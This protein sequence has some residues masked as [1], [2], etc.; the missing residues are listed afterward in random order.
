MACWP[1]L[2]AELSGGLEALGGALEG[3]ERAA[4]AVSGGVDSAFLLH[5]ARE[6]LGAARVTGV[7][8]RSRLQ[9]AEEAE[10]AAAACRAEG[11]R[12]VVVDFEPLAV[13]GFAANPP[14]RCYLCK[15]ALFGALLERCAAE[16]LGTLA[17]GTNAD[18][19]GDYRPGL[20]ALRELGVRSPLL[21]AGLGK[22]AVRELSRAMGLVMWDKPS[23]ACL[24][25]RFPH[26][27]R[28]AAEGLARVEAAERLV[29]GTVAGVRQLRV[30]VH[31]NVARIETER[32]SAGAVLARA[33]DVAAGLR[34]LGYRYVALDLEGF[35]SGSLNPAAEEKGGGR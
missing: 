2:N 3:M 24:A 31:G 33:G 15:R 10:D 12:Q 1:R 8:A 7:T 32:E 16:G 21:E 30:R 5:V 25:T 34:G 13:E 17:E 14:E 22:A 11:V 27:D 20:R 28:I 6:V 18:D 29:R 23:L 26:G 9:S 4:V 35:R 19:V